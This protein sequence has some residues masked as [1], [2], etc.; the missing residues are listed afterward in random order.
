MTW[1]RGHG[2]TVVGSPHN[3][4]CWHP[5][6]LP[7]GKIET[8]VAWNENW[9]TQQGAE[10]KSQYSKSMWIPE[11]ANLCEASEKVGAVYHRKS[12]V[13]EDFI[14]KSSKTWQHQ[15]CVGRGTTL[16]TRTVPTFP[17]FWMRG[18]VPETWTA[19]EG[20][21]TTPWPQ[22]SMSWQSD[23]YFSDGSSGVHSQDV[24]LRRAGWGIV[25]VKQTQS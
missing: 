18:L 24:R 11:D 9:A 8:K 17:C 6:E 7:Q 5:A 23:G 4:D 12:A 25:C 21:E 15:S 13:A 19:V 2:G 10:A 1:K 22:G 20:N 16:G 14:M 3:E